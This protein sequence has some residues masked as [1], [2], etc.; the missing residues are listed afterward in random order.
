LPAVKAGR[1]A[2][3][4]NRS[5]AVMGEEHWFLLLSCYSHRSR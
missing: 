5:C 1:S 4:A 3:R 2:A